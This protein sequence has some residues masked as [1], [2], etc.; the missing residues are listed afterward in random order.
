[1]V[2]IHSS[3]SPP[4]RASGLPLSGTFALTTK[5]AVFHFPLFSN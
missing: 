4:A 5:G 1:M 3:E 2:Q